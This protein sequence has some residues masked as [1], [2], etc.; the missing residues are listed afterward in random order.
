VS[1]RKQQKRANQLVRAQRAR[2]R[3]RRIAIWTTA[4]VVA[5]LVIGAT[6]TVVIYQVQQN[7]KTAGQYAM[8]KGS[9]KT[10]LGLVAANGSVPV[11]LYVDFMCPHCKEF[12]ETASGALDNFTQSN[13]IRLVY[14]PVNILDSDS[15]GTEFSTRAGAAAA[16]ASDAGQVSEFVT[17]L[18]AKQPQEGSTGLTDQQIIDAAKSGGVTATSFPTCVKSGKYKKWVSHVTEQFT[19]KGYTGTPTVV[20]NGSVV[21]NPTVDELT[22]AINAA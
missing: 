21:Q 16:C 1:S 20:V 22:K 4:A 3:K 19:Q 17:A 2:E 15:S 6:V 9:T 13:K 7:A 14:H 12:E 10:N 18:Y 8:P 5:L 11:D